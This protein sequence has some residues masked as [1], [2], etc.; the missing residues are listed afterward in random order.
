MADVARSGPLRHR[1]RPVRRGP[2]PLRLP[3]TRHRPGRPLDHRRCHGHLRTRRIE[4]GRRRR[5]A[6]DAAVGDPA[7]DVLRI[8]TLVALG[9]AFAWYAVLVVCELRWPR[10]HYDVRRW[11]T[12]FPLA[13]TAVAALSTSTAAAVPALWTCGKVLIWPALAVWAVVAAGAF[14]AARDRTGAQASAG[15]TPQR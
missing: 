5:A 14:R 7:H 15:L 11:A 8:V 3:P 10:L 2:D 12:V 4:A 13:M 6:G 9:L 1:P